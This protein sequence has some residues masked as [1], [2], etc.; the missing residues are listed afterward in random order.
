[1]DVELDIVG[2]IGASSL[3]MMPLLSTSL[4]KLGAV[5]LSGATSIVRSLWLSTL[6]PPNLVQKHLCFPLSL[7]MRPQ[8]IK[9]LVVSARDD[10]TCLRCDMKYKR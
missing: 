10:S 7:K 5:W 8:E 6:V 9:M 1:M 3:G 4:I 2:L